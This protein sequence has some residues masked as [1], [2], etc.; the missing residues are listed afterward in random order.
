[1][2]V[3]ACDA[4]SAPGLLLLA[5]SIMGHASR[6]LPRWLTRAGILLGII[7]ELAGLTLVPKFAAPCIPIARFLGFAWMIA[8]GT[9]LKVN[10]S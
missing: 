7:A 4:R 1:M 10:V 3:G 5:V 2:V 8:V 9:S 6:T